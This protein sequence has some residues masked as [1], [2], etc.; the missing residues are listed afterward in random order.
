MNFDPEDI[1]LSAG[2]KVG[3]VIMAITFLILLFQ[4]P[5]LKRAKDEAEVAEAKAR[6]A[7]AEAEAAAAQQKVKFAATDIP[8]DVASQ[9]A[10]MKTQTELQIAL[11]RLEEEIEAAAARNDADTTLKYTRKRAQL[12][13]ELENARE[14]ARRKALAA[15]KR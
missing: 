3:L 12:L 9:V 15:A 13:R 11:K 7:K 1:R 14:K 4:N 8:L 5:K 10:L 2:A 6:K